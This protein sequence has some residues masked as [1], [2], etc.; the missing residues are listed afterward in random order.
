M[1]GWAAFPV[2]ARGGAIFVT[3]VETTGAGR[4]FRVVNG[5]FYAVDQ[6]SGELRWMLHE[7]DAVFGGAPAV[8][9]ELV[10]LGS[11][12]V[13]GEGSLHAFDIRTG[14]VEWVFDAGNRI[15]TPPSVAD[16]LV[17]QRFCIDG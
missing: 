15:F 4:S 14:E 10:L 16:G 5:R 2:A 17:V 7:E 11:V 9:E 8:T 3:T 1:E 13:V 6:S 12:G